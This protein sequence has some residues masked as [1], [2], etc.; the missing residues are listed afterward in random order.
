MLL[1]RMHAKESNTLTVRVGLR[2]DLYTS[3]QYLWLVST[4]LG[5]SWVAACRQRADMT[6][7]LASS[8]GVC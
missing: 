2:R 8:G 4:S 5:A 3:S 1:L 7:L 6:A